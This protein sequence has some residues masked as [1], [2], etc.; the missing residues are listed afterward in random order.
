[1]CFMPVVFPAISVGIV[2]L[3]FLTIPIQMQKEYDPKAGKA[4]EKVLGSISGTAF[5]YLFGMRDA[6]K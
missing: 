1:M 6:E 2:A 3:S 5:F 4:G